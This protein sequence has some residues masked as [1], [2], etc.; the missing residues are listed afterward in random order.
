MRAGAR[1]RG[2]RRLRD[3]RRGASWRCPRSC[4]RST[5]G[6]D[7]D[8]TCR[9]CAGA[10]RTASVREGV[11]RAAA[12][13]ARGDRRCRWSTTRSCAGTERRTTGLVWRSRGLPGA[14]R[15]LRGVRDL[16]ALRA[17]RRGDER[18]RADAP[19]GGRRAGRVPHRRQRGGEQA[20]VQALPARARSTAASRSLL[21]VQMRAD[22]VFDRDGRLDRE[23]LRLLKRV[24]SHDDACA[25]AWSPRPTRTSRRS[26]ST[27]TARACARAL[28]GDAALRPA[29]ARHVHRV[30]G[31]HARDAAPQRRATRG[32]TSRRCSTCS[33]RRCRA[34]SARPSTSAPGGCC[35]AGS[36][37]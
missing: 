11:P 32:G 21:V 6:E 20:V 35:S 36:R 7:A 17:A 9:A 30:R 5:R 18:R 1:V 13:D 14:L 15:L 34:R 4:A 25:S 2:G 31:R 23:L 37:T 28:R 19:P 8:A 12:D 27:S 33:R 26:A 29:R 16:A 24:A 22:A 3:P 10:T